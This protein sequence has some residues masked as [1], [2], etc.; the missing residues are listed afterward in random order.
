MNGR[1]HGDGRASS[2]AEQDN[3]SWSMNEVENGWTRTKKWKS[4][5]EDGRSDF[6]ARHKSSYKKKVMGIN[7]DTQMDDNEINL[8]GEVSNDDILE[9]KENGP[10]FSIGMSKQEKIKAGKPRHLSLIIKLVGCNTKYH[11]LLQ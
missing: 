9:E 5:E 1:Q 3:L 11:F 7:Q 10:W 8:D 4:L 2:D 6:D